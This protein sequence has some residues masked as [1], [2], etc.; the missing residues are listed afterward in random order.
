MTH[1]VLIM[2]LP[3]SGKATLARHLMARLLNNNITAAW[4]NAID[5]RTQCN[6]WD[7]SIEGRVRQSIRMRDLADSCTREVAVCDFIAPLPVMRDNFSPHLLVW[8]DTV[9]SGKFE[10]TNQ[11]FIKPDVF[12]FRVTE[13]DSSFWSK[14]IYT[15][16]LNTRGDK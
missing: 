16:I 7:F 11:M 10:G 2:G 3:G 4:I 1:R 15:A 9:S 13:K 14:E 6:D 5:A 8:V 12:D